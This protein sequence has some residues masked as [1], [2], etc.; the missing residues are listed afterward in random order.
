MPSR[1][2]SD[3]DFDTSFGDKAGPQSI[4]GVPSDRVRCA[5][6][7]VVPWRDWSSE[8]VPVRQQS[9]PQ[10]RSNAEQTATDV[11]QRDR[12]LRLRQALAELDRG[13]I[14]RALRLGDQA[15]SELA[16]LSPQNA[17]SPWCRAWEWAVLSTFRTV[18]GDLAGGLQFAIF[19]M[20]MLRMSPSAPAGASDRFVRPVVEADLLA[21]AGFALSAI[22]GGRRLDRC[23]ILLERAYVLHHR[24]GDNES[25]AM[26]LLLQARVLQRQGRVLRAHRCLQR[27]TDLAAGC[28]TRNPGCRSWRL[29]TWLQET[30][31]QSTDFGLLPP[32]E[33]RPLN[34]ERSL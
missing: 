8:R 24:G 25:A 28:H 5:G 9:R 12:P 16:S 7:S 15:V 6:P 34:G 14:D 1:S 3:S 2:R 18:A 32:G 17:V 19:G 21:S 13:N 11:S 4:P 26:D 31:R 27:A 23:A 22:R 30:L 20:R 29:L 10:S 33:H